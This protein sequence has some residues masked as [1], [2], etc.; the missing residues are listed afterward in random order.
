MYWDKVSGVYSKIE[1]YS[2]EL[3]NAST[4]TIFFF[5][6]SFGRE[7]YFKINSMKKQ[8]RALLTHSG[9]GSSWPHIP[10]EFKWTG[11]M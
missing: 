2:V 7:K 5:H 4:V 9:L 1:I 8:D 11:I 6:S 3:R 10:S